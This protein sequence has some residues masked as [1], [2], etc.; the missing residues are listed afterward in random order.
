MKRRKLFVGGKKTN[1]KMNHNLPD[2][3]SEKMDLETINRIIAIAERLPTD[4]HSLRQMDVADIM[5][6]EQW[7]VCYE[8]IDRNARDCIIPSSDGTMLVKSC[9]TKEVLLAQ[10][11][12]LR[13][14]VKQAEHDRDLNNQVLADTL[15]NNRTTRSIAWISLVVSILALLASVVVPLL[16]D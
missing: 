7:I 8:W 3:R 5:S 1:L 4:G 6:A 9:K 14:E 2:E 16:N 11:N 15:K 13:D 10:L 12:H